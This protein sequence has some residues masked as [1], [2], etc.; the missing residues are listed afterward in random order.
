VLTVCY[1]HKSQKHGHLEL[2]TFVCE[3]VMPGPMTRSKNIQTLK[4]LSRNQVIHEIPAKDLFSIL[5]DPNE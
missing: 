5:G 2:R 1:W 3:C 4:L